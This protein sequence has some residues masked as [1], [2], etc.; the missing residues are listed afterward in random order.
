[1][2]NIDDEQSVV[3][4]RLAEPAHNT[5]VLPGASDALGDHDPGEPECG[6]VEARG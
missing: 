1:M 4:G 6:L 3:W 2:I 5:L